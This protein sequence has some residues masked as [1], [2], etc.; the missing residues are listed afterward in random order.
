MRNDFLG[1]GRRSRERR[2]QIGAKKV[3][4]AK[5]RRRQDAEV[6]DRSLRVAVVGKE[7]IPRLAA[8]GGE[9]WRARFDRLDPNGGRKEMRARLGHRVDA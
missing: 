6:A 8:E 4:T 3:A 9:D 5:A 1:S 7:V 2:H